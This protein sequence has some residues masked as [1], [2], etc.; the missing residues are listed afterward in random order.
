MGKSG[1]ISIWFFVGVLLII[2]G[3]LVL[4]AGIYGLYYPPDRE[5]VLARLHAGIW[6]GALLLILGG[7]YSY[8]FFPGRGNEAGDAEAASHSGDAAHPQ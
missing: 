1:H 8:S 2:Y 5:V 7:I 4:G 3:V 6:W